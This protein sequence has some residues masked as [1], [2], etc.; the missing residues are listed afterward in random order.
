MTSVA[1]SF[2][3]AA[4]EIAPQVDKTMTC[5]CLIKIDSRQPFGVLLVFPFPIS[6]ASKTNNTTPSGGGESPNRGVG[7]AT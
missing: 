3:S 2:A 6:E 7:A 1:H 4:R 5:K